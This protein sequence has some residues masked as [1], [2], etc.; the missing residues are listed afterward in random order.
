MRCRICE[1]ILPVELLEEH[2]QLCVLISK[3]EI[4]MQHVDQ[5]LN[6]LTERVTAEEARID[7]LPSLSEENRA[8]KL[9]LQETRTVIHSCGAVLCSR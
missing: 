6:K 3:C 7:A 4:E 1:D 5:T 2:S 9:V 8:D